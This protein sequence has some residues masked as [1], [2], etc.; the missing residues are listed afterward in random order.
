M[1]WSDSQ[2]AIAKYPTFLKPYVTCL[3]CF[4]AAQR[5]TMHSIVAPFLNK[6]PATVKAVAGIVGPEIDRR[7]ALMDD[8]GKDY[9]GK[10]VNIKSGG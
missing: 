6:L 2:N 9:P 4:G 7:R 10:T 5:F 8:Y 3:P 1:D